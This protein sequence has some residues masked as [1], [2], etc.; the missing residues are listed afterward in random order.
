M[1]NRCHHLCWSGSTVWEQLPEQHIEKG[2]SVV[3]GRWKWNSKFHFGAPVITSMLSSSLSPV[4]LNPLCM[5]PPSHNTHTLTSYTHPYRTH[6][7]MHKCTHSA[8]TH[9]LTR[10]HIQCIQA[11]T[12]AYTHIYAVPRQPGKQTG[13]HKSSVSSMSYINLGKSFCQF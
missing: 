5:S 9:K 8:Q 11:H 2:S 12:H 1:A 13:I 7:H 3:L 6:T 4:I 10:V